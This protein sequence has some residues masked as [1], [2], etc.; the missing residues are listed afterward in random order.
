MKILPINIVNTMIII[1][2][3]VFECLLSSFYNKIYLIISII[4]G[5]IIGISNSF[6]PIMIIFLI[7]IFL[8]Y[9]YLI[10]VFQNIILKNF[11]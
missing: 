1:S 4:L 3:Y 8:Y 2:A 7:A 9:L 6:R 5:I 10:K 11:Y